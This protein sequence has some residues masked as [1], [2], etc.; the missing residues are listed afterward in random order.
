M[1]TKFKDFVV[2]QR[3]LWRD[4]K[5]KEGKYFSDRTISGLQLMTTSIKRGATRG[6]TIVVHD[7]SLVAGAALAHIQTNSMADGKPMSIWLMGSAHIVEGAGSAMY[8]A[9]LKWGQ[10]QGVTSI[11]LD[12]LPDAKTFW[13]TKMR[14]IW[15]GEEMVYSDSKIGM[16][17]ALK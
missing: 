14:M 7:G 8:G 11:E 5:G 10:S 2:E 12:P 17:G 13:Q 6:T 3:N 9:L 1:H 16:I 15:T 4:T